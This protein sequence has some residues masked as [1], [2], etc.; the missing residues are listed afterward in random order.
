MKNQI[1]PTQNDIPLNYY[2]GLSALVFVVL[3]LTTFY[4]SALAEKSMTDKTV[5]PA[6]TA[7]V[8]APVQPAT[9]S[10]KDNSII[11]NIEF[12]NNQVS[13]QDSTGTKT[14]DLH[15]EGVRKK[16]IA[17]L[18]ISVYKISLFTPTNLVAE[19]SEFKVLEA[20]TLAVMMEPLR[21]FGGD[22]M[23][24]SIEDSFKTNSVDINAQAHQD[25]VKLISKSKIK[26][27]EQIFL[28]GMQN[29]ATKKE[30][31]TLKR[32]DEVQV[33]NG[34]TGFVKEIFAIWLGKTSDTQLGQLKDQLL[35]K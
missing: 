24:A 26:K 29:P 31:L 21:S 7:P 28:I 19:K 27:G 22:K 30:T 34:H 14:L 18:N 15:G 5:T 10:T 9:D 32:G 17:F 6:K 2:F 11:K 8:K 20:P 16:K 12:K 33:I 1:Q 4:N 3:F 23:K 25:F 13:F 35:G